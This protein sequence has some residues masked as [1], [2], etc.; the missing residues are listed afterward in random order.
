[1]KPIILSLTFAVLSLGAYAQQLHESFKKEPQLMQALKT[2]DFTSLAAN[3]VAFEFDT[4]Q[5]QASPAELNQLLRQ[6]MVVGKQQTLRKAAEANNGYVQTMGVYTKG[7][8][9]LL[10]I[11]FE[12]DPLTSKLIEVVIQRN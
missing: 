10:Y 2:Y 3:E 8:D 9:A 12:F 5:R 4:I 1:M 6:H 7:D 11:K